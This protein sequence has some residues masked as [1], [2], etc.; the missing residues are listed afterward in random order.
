MEKKIRNVRCR[1]K[2]NVDFRTYKH[3]NVKHCFKECWWQADVVMVMVM[4][5]VV[6]VAGRCGD[7]ATRREDLARWT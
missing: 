7:G 5:M 6:M 1:H 2:L 3:Y 4:V